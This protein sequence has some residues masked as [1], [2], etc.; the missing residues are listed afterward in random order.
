[1]PPDR[2]THQLRKLSRFMSLLLRHRPAR[3]PIDLD[4]QGYADLDEVM[5]FV[6][7]LPNFRWA[8]YRD[9]DAV[10]DLPG[11]QRFERVREADGPT[12]IRALYGHTAVRPTYAPAAP[13][14]VLYH[15]TDPETLPAI[16]RDGLRPMDRQ[17][18][19]LT[20]DVETARRTGLRH[21]GDPVVLAVDAEAAHADGVVFYHPV[22]EIYLCDHGPSVY[23]RRVAV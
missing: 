3:F 11:R 9:V 19:H 15:G 1:M 18:V 21:A 22:A 2:S 6:R 8:T 14:A 16:E 20:V 10:L 23:I 13:P 12:R 4:A 17:Y 7:A 5:H